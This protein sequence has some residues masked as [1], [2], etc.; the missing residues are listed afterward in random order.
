M[1]TTA[2]H[3]SAT[4]GKVATI[5][6]LYVLS[7]IIVLLGA[8]F[9]V[10]SAINDVQLTVMTSKIP[11]VVFGMVVLFLGVRYF[12]SLSKLKEEVFK[13]AGFSWSNFRKVKNSKA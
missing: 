13:S 12:M 5:I 10:Y 4:K 1:R 11:G 3:P 6:I 8:G 2:Q 9:C 7:V